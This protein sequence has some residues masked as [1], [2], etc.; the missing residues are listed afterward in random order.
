MQSRQ[1]IHAT[2]PP[3]LQGIA[4]G[5][6]LWLWASTAFA[7][8]A[9]GV[10]GGLV[11]GLLHPVL[12]LD[13]LVAM[14]AVGLW[15]AQLGS[16]ALWLLPIVFPMIMALGALLGVAGLPLPL[17]ELGIAA[18]ALALGFAVAGALR[19]PLWAALLL[20]T[21]FAVFHG[22]AHG[23]E[24]PSAANPL[25]Y[26][27]GFVIS[28]GLLHVAGILLGALTHFPSGAR[29]VRGCGAAVAAVGVFYIAADLGLLS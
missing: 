27:V 20:V 22:H 18:S 11:S 19:P 23:T 21:V 3:M 7:H 14:V 4:A 24:V 2:R 29:L 1:T 26:G 17:I 5:A 28:T 16:P 13:H 25:A 8:S 12:G 15:G 6:A 10:A 9:S